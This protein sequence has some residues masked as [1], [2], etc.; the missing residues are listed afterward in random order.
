MGRR[1][2]SGG[3]GGKKGTRGE[4]VETEWATE[5]GGLAPTHHG[6]EE[7]YKE[8]TMWERTLKKNGRHSCH[9]NHFRSAKN[10]KGSNCKVG[11]TWGAVWM[12][13]NGGTEIIAIFVIQDDRCYTGKGY[14]EARVGFPVKLPA[15][16]LEY[17]RVSMCSEP[18][19]HRKVLEYQ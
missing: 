7:E 11:L 8:R 3:G 17:G 6:K 14:I 13:Y 10:N 19:T 12:D 5:S 15:S 4:V 1:R 18:S 16:L 9:M 2:R